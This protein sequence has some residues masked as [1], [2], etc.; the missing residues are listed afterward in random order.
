[1]FYGMDYTKGL[2]PC[3]VFTDLDSVFFVVAVKTLAETG[4]RALNCSIW[5][6]GQPRGGGTVV[7][8]AGTK[9]CCCIKK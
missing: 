3:I 7:F 9:L 1:M 4:S 8:S 5:R 6:C 2:I